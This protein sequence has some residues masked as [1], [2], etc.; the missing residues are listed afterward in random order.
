MPIKQIHRMNKRVQMLELHDA[1]VIEL[2]IDTMHATAIL[3]DGEEIG[4]LT[5]QA[6]SSLN[7]IDISPLYK[8][9]SYV[10]KK[11][12]LVSEAEVICS[13]AI[14]HFRSFTNGRINVPKNIKIM[15]GS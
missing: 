12:S 4:R 14:D 1:Q 6:L 5:F 8:V 15:Q 9:H 13:C 10:L 7:N 3:Q 11:G 2:R